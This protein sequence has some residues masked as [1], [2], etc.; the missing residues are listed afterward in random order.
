MHFLDISAAPMSTDTLATVFKGLFVVLFIIV[1]YI[2]R[3]SKS[4]A[5]KTDNKKPIV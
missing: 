2:Y 3:D 1:M 4:S 5:R